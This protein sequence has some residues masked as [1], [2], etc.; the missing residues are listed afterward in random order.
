[1]IQSQHT[2]R[3][4]FI[5]WEWLGSSQKYLGPGVPNRWT[6]LLTNCRWALRGSGC[7]VVLFYEKKKKNLF[8]WIPAFI[9]LQWGW[10][11]SRLSNTDF[12][13]PF[14]LHINSALWKAVEISLNMQSC[15]HRPLY[16]CPV[17]YFWDMQIWHFSSVIAL[18]SSPSLH[19]SLSLSLSTTKRWNITC[20]AL[21]NITADCSICLV[22]LERNLLSLSLFHVLR[23][24]VSIFR[25]RNWTTFQQSASIFGGT[26]GRTISPPKF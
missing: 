24:L 3:L 8:S 5:L 11:V 16:V 9:F 6:S 13:F 26:V 25:E 19:V 18:Q 21:P 22:Q 12:I 7:H 4:R 14:K 1:M 15:V 20:S 10:Y 23:L 17:M 2:S